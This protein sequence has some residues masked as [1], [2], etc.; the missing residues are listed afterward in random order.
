MRIPFLIFLISAALIG[1]L[2]V[3]IRTA[4]MPV[5]RWHVDPEAATRP[6][7]PNFYMLRDGDG[8]APALQL[9]A[10][11]AEAAAALDRI[12]EARRMTR[13]LAGAASDGF[14]TY[15]VRTPVFGF[16]DAVSIR[17]TET[18]TGTRVA[19]FSRSRF[20]RSDLGAN[21]AR[22]AAIVADLTAAIA[23]NAP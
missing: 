15:I 16:P 10:P 18:E 12:M 23:P 1:V 13:R 19:I 3:L 22:V 11:P 20:G 4:P 2:L 9:S 21:R 6:T 5:A 14:V 7:T 17:L 8:D